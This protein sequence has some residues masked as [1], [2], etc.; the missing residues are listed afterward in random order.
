MNVNVPTLNTTY[1][2]SHLTLCHMKNTLLFSFGLDHHTPA[3]SKNITTEV[4]FEPFYQS[5][6][7]NLTRAMSQEPN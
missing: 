6:L 7:R 5:L 1:I 3:K 2:I 4:E